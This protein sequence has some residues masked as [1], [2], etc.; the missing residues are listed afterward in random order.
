KADKTLDYVPNVNYNGADTIS[1]TIQN[2]TGPANSTVAVTVDPVND[3]PTISPVSASVN[4]NSANNTAVT[5]MTG[6]D[7]DVDTLT[8]SI[9][10][11]SA[12]IFGIDSNTGAITISDNT[13]LNY[14]TLTSH[15]ITVKAQ[16]PGGLFNTADAT[17]TV[18][19]LE[20]NVT[21]TLDA[22][23]ATAGTGGAN[24]F[25]AEHVDYPNDSVIDASGKLVVVGKNDYDGPTTDL[26]IARYNTDGTLDRTFGNQGLVTK[27][28]GDDEEG[29]AVAID[30]AG[31][32]V[33]AGTYIS[34]SSAFVFAIR[35]T[36]TG[37]LDTSFN[38]G[39][40]YHIV[41]EAA[42]PTFAADI[43]IHP[44][45]SIVVAATRMDTGDMAI[46]NFSADGTSHPTLHLDFAGGPDMAS[47]I[48]LQSD[49][50]ALLIG[51][52]DN[53]SFQND[54]AVARY[55]ITPTFELDTSY[56][57]DG[58]AFFD[59]GNSV[60]DDAYASAI[61]ST[62]ELYI[63]GSTITNGVPDMAA[64]KIDSD[65]NLLSGFDSNGLLIVDIDNDF[66]SGSNLSLVK[67]M[68]VDS[69][70]NL[71]FAIEIGPTVATIDNVIYKTD[72][73]GAVDNTYGSSG[74]VTFDHNSDEN[75]IG[76][77]VI[78]NSDR[79]VLL[80]TAIPATDIP[81]DLLVAR[82]TAAGALDTSFS[83][84][85]ITTLDP[86]FNTDTLNELIELI[87]AAHAGKFVAVGTAASDSGSKMIVA[88]FNA[89]G[90]IDESFGHN[91]YFIYSEVEAT[92][93]GKDV[94][95]DLLARAVP[96][97]G[98]GQHELDDA[99]DTRWQVQQQVV[100]LPPVHA[101]QQLPQ[102][103]ELLGGSP[104]LR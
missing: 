96:L 29:V 43:K 37:I 3:A 54:F 23:F 6:S 41:G 92:I 42:G 44:S 67:A 58:K 87:V 76:D 66:G 82:F 98:L 8:Y 52:A 88:R 63:A 26:F 11:N 7:V 34:G 57:G 81:P 38:S 101:R 72:A 33:V 75:I 31:N 89:D 17:I 103:R 24:S 61:L 83:I 86:T 39:T 68:A 32:I 91:G 2:A 93:T 27:D 90:T 74:Q 77:L 20:E 18:N 99:L 45:G 84:D 53:S 13:S 94:V 79:A 95:G 59:F 60:D 51:T 5:T 102:D 12:N 36:S 64:L 62:D 71:F 56:N 78:D 4:E 16:D 30:G 46:L 100:E 48:E 19:N 97:F 80:T 15:T 85:G 47:S 49:G 14:E 9:T 65:G 50:K 25:S 10:A 1:Y 22:S 104:R 55:N 73:T 70:N 35:Y 21:P 69:S 40:G 28:L